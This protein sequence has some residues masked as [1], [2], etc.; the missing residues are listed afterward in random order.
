VQ[1]GEYL[2]LLRSKEKCSAFFC[3]ALAVRAKYLQ[4]LTVYYRSTRES[5]IGRDAI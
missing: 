5:C 3:Y 2:A 4:I 1:V